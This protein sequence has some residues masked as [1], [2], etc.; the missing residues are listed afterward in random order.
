MDPRSYHARPE[1]G[2][3]GGGVV[4]HLVRVPSSRDST[5]K[6]C[7][8]HL[9]WC[10][11]AE[12]CPEWP[13]WSRFTPSTIESESLMFFTFARS[14]WKNPYLAVVSEVADAAVEPWWR[15]PR[16]V[17]D[18]LGAPAQLERGDHVEDELLPGY[19]LRGFTRAAVLI[20]HVWCPP[21]RQ[22][23][24]SGPRSAERSANRHRKN[25]F[26]VFLGCVY[27]VLTPCPSRS[28][29]TVNVEHCANGDQHFE[30]QNGFWTLMVT[31]MVTD[32]E[33]E[34]VNRH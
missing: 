16:W 20:R 29:V 25:T 7:T 9:S 2:G 23:P 22:T 18:L 14:V 3:V 31:M 8:P 11:A 30:G 10:F 1:L 5:W 19:F 27:K 6:G 17:V 13:C 33:S 32:T 4:D 15:Q 26:S 24:R 21:S 28:Y 12:S 34:H